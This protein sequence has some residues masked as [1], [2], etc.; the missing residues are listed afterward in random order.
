MSIMGYPYKLMLLASFLMLYLMAGSMAEQPTTSFQ[1]AQAR[2][3]TLT[4]A[5]AIAEARTVA[6]TYWQAQ[7]TSNGALFH[8]VTPHD[9]MLVVFGWSF[10]TQSAITVEE[11]SI[12]PIRDNFQQFLALHQQY[13][14]LPV[15]APGRMEAVTQSAMYAKMIETDHPL[16]GE[17]F[18]KSYWETITPPNFANANRYRLKSAL[19]CGLPGVALAMWIEADTLALRR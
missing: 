12:P 6:E 2:T 8:S 4:D 3:L 10:V 14:S 9:S 11:G 13:K 7:K 17:F 18:R 1:T 19:A 15:L 5:K 16:L